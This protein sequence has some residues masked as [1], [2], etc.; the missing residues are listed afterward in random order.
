M[1]SL[2]RRLAVLWK[3]CFFSLEWVGSTTTAADGEDLVTVSLRFH[4]LQGK[5]ARPSRP[6]NDEA[7]GEVMYQVCGGDSSSSLLS[8]EQPD[9][10]DIV[11]SS[12][13]PIRS[14]HVISI[15]MPAS[16][17]TG[18]EAMIRLQWVLACMGALSGAAK[19]VDGDERGGESYD[20]WVGTAARW[21]EHIPDLPE[22]FDD[23]LGVREGGRV[24]VKR[25]GSLTIEG[26]STV[27]SFD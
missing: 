17:L 19:D 5:T 6:V 20:Q 23:G 13:T 27:M 16:E 8:L 3:R 10:D 15:R 12:G 11:L 4:W 1:I 18:F 26:M 9:G 14:G 24:V 2:D 7:L 22:R 21:L 25:I